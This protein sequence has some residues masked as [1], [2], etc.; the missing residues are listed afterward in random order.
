M[1]AASFPVPEG[2]VVGRV[3]REHHLASNVWQ[4]DLNSFRH[5]GLGFHR[6]GIRYDRLWLTGV[7]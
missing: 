2:Q 5:Q 1:D 6:V 4:Q 3:L 7:D